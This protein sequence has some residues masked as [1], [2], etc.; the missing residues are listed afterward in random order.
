[1]QDVL[2]KFITQ[3]D[4][5]QFFFRF[6]AKK[7]FTEMCCILNMSICICHPV[8]NFVECYNLIKGQYA[9][10]IYMYYTRKIY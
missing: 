8:Y 7:S 5:E 9:I 6:W 4:R 1:M 10:T 2:L 3:I